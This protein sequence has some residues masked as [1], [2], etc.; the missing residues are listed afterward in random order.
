MP[1]MVQTNE[2]VCRK[3]VR[4]NVSNE[5]EDLTSGSLQDVV[6]MSGDGV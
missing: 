3:L 4:A 2:V 5:V 6:K 1:D